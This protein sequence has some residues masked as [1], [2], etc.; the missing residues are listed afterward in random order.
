MKQLTPETVRQLYSVMTQYYDTEIIYHWEDD[1]KDFIELLD[2]FLKHA[3]VPDKEF[4]KQVCEINIGHS[5][6]LPVEPGSKK[7]SLLTQVAM[8]A[9]IHQRS[10]TL[11]A[12]EYPEEAMFL[13]MLSPTHRVQAELEADRA[14][15]EVRYWYAKAN[16]IEP[17]LPTLGD[18]LG[19][20]EVYGCPTRDDLVIERIKKNM[21]SIESGEVQCTAAL[22]VIG[23][24]GW[25]P[26]VA[27]I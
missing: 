9:S 5:L 19:K 7:I 6:Y 13:Y 23:F 12:H 3:G 27:P 21:A 26:H 16:N 25:K 10:H 24:Y 1:R 11:D 22:D 14:Y 8:C 4:F 2:V 20:L 18:I 15:H 17:Q